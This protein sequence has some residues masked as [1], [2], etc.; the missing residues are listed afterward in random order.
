MGALLYSSLE[1]ESTSPLSLSNRGLA[2]G[3]GIFETIRVV[4]AKVP[5]LDYHR[6][7]FLRGVEVLS[8]GSSLELLETFDDQLENAVR[9][10]QLH[11]HENGLVKLIA[12][13]KEGGRGYAPIEPSSVDLFIQVFE[14]PHYQESYYSS[15]IELA[16][17]SHRLSEQP[18]LAG[19]KHLN[20]LDQV[21]GARE[22][23]GAPEGVMLDQK[24][25]VIEGTKSN[26]IALIDGTFYTPELSVCGIRG[27]LLS[28]LLAGE[29]E[30]FDGSF[31][32]QE[33]QMTLD[34]LHQAD[35]LLMIN[36]VFGVWPVSQFQQS[37][38][39]PSTQVNKMMSAVKQRF[40]FDYEVA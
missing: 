23:N 17:C 38:Y 22:L 34:D 40:G 37:K 27:T 31:A 39:A 33:R 2:Y 28:A 12:T 4:Q 32:I 5:L 20:R 21:M 7:R 26:L 1:E 19:I 29:L 9:Q 13:R 15:G 8:L 30:E 10:L 24:N 11:G 25:H 16:L 6:A 14:L 35:A 36:S 3:D 18:M